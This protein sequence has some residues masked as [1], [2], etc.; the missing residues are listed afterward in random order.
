M[1][2]QDATNPGADEEELV[3]TPEVETDEAEA[4]AEEATE[5]DDS[6]DAAPDPDLDDVEYEGKQ[7]KVPKELRDALLRQADYTKK[8]QELAAGRKQI[9]QRQAEL[10]QLAEIQTQTV[11][12]R[13]QLYAIESRLAD[14]QRLDWDAY[15]AQVGSDVA[16]RA[17]RD[18]QVL[19]EARADLTQAISVKERKIVEDQQKQAAQ[20]RQQF[21]QGLKSIQGWDDETDAEITKVMIK[22]GIAP[23]EI[24]A[25]D[26][27][28]LVP[29]FE[30]MAHGIKAMKVQ[31]EPAP[32]P[33]TDF[34]PI[35]K[36]SQPAPAG[37][38]PSR[39]SDAEWIKWRDKQ[40][41][42]KRR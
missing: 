22:A 36:V 35:T 32:K 2:D 5:D 26:D 12:E 3:S 20:G 9:E 27:A 19:K 28:R 41:S 16:N 6:E 24:Q 14:F 42:A 39:M 21:V 15:E 34:K 30:V 1:T 10:A 13:A 8:T 23:E 18:F 40:V 31:A 4:D 37:K 7:Y 17:W 29:L 11:Q 33:K 25:L 38:D